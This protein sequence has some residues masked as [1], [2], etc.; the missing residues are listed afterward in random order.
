M[1]D[2]RLNEYF[3]IKR[4][5][6]NKNLEQV[7]KQLNIDKKELSS[8]ENGKIKITNHY[9]EKYNSFFKIVHLSSKEIK[10][11][12]KWYSQ[13]STSILFY[14][15]RLNIFLKC[16]IDITRLSFSIYY[17]DYLVMKYICYPDKTLQILLEKCLIKEDAHNYFAFSIFNANY[18]MI[19]KNIDKAK[20][21]I[22]DN[23]SINKSDFFYP[24]YLYIS[25]SI[26]NRTGD[27]HKSISNLK[28]AISIF[29]QSNNTKRYFFSLIIRAIQETNLKDY[30]NSEQIYCTLLNNYQNITYY[31]LD[32]I[33]FNLSW[34]YIRQKEYKKSIL[35]LNQITNK[36]I[37]DN[38]FYFLY[39]FNNYKLNNYDECTKYI[40]Y[41]QNSPQ[42]NSF[43][44]K[45]LTILIQ[46]LKYGENYRYETR[47]KN[48]LKRSY[49]VND[50]TD[51]H[52][53]LT[54]LLEYY[55]KRNLEYL[56]EETLK[57]YN[58]L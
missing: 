31:D 40:I 49:K 43:C 22:K 37:M 58:E 54:Q 28:E 30:K 51:I 29:K 41:S 9:Q 52:F 10:Q 12:H 24:M 11:F 2:Y 33:R 21:W 57:K 36:S 46:A 48:L 34:A 4:L 16:P 47:L 55:Q 25:A 26:Y 19:N 14:E 56:Y 15:N 5:I 17:I 23:L 18:Y 50:L 42:N 35:I 3:K 7:S 38:E 8:I 53:V 44:S 20:F 6:E 32:Y 13:L 39:A 45:Y 27:I 1:Y